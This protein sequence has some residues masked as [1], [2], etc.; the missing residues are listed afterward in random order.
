MHR[1]DQH[2]QGPTTGPMRPLIVVMENTDGHGEESLPEQ[3][4]PQDDEQDRLSPIPAEEKEDNGT[5][6]AP[7]PNEPNGHVPPPREPRPLALPVVAA[8]TPRSFPLLVA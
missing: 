8:H 3:G 5:P 2:P 1:R 4:T 6:S 7:P